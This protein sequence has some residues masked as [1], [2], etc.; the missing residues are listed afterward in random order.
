MDQK[1]GVEIIERACRAPLKAIANNAVST[2]QHLS[3]I[4]LSVTLRANFE[5]FGHITLICIK[6]TNY[7]LKAK[8]IYVF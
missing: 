3:L 5:L 8:F 6:L 4:L 7:N 1:I 2:L